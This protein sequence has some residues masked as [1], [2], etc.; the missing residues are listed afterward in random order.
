MVIDAG[1]EGSYYPI[2]TC[3]TANGWDTKTSVRGVKYMF[4]NP[5]KEDE[6]ETF[7]YLC[8]QNIYQSQVD[9]YGGYVGLVA[10]YGVGTYAYS[11]DHY[12]VPQFCEGMYNI[13]HI[14]KIIIN[15]ARI[16]ISC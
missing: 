16:S 1:C 14:N 13:L 7:I 15:I 2:G 6:D 9:S 12:D 11:C 10:Y 4:D 3:T 5:I 8:V